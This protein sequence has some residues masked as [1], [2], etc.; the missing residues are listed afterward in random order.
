MKTFS[1]FDRARIEASAKRG[2]RGEEKEETLARRP[3]YFGLLRS[4]T[5]G[6]SDRCGMLPMI[7]N[8]S[9]K[10]MQF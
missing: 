7:D 3:C 4:P 5:N 1:I 9:M 8:S 10:S 2:L 6:V